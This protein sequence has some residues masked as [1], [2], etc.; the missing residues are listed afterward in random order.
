MQSIMFMILTIS[1]NSPNFITLINK[2]YMIIFIL[3]TSVKGKAVSHI[4][5]PIARCF[6]S[7]LVNIYHFYIKYLLLN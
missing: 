7:I 6:C 4:K 1:F 3:T 5:K 2:A